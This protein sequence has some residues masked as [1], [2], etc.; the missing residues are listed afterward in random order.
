MEC[1]QCGFLFFS[2]ERIQSHLEMAHA[3]PMNTKYF[4]VEFIRAIPQDE[5]KR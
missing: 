3:L 2:E 1:P 5:K 4:S